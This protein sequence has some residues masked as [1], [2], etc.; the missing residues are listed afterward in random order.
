MD[1][2]IFWGGGGGGQWYSATACH[3]GG[4]GGMPPRFFFFNFRPSES[5]SGTFSDHLGMDHITNANYYLE[6]FNT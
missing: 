6:G 3:L 2:K 5:A 1:S 4:S